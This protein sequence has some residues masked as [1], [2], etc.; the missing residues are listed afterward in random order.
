MKK[1]VLIVE[2]EVLVGMMLARNIEGAGFSVCEVVG[3]GED[4]VAAAE[5]H[6]PGVILM[7]VSLSGEMDGIEAAGRIRSLLGIPVVFFTGYRQDKHLMA[8]ANEVNALAVLDK[9]GPI[10]DIVAALD[11]AFR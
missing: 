11:S 4:A 9:L 5:R 7:D 10:E 2:D 6:R 1:T 8:R 3:T